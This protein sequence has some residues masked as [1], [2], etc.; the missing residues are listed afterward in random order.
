MQEWVISRGGSMTLVVVWHYFYNT[1]LKTHSLQS[2]WS[3]F[4]ALEAFDITNH[5]PILNTCP[6]SHSCTCLCSL[7]QL[8]PN[9]E[10]LDVSRTRGINFL[11]ITRL[12]QGCRTLKGFMAK[13]CCSVLLRPVFLFLLCDNSHH[14]DVCLCCLWRFCCSL[15]H[16]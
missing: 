7:G 6:S 2:N 1:N 3:S 5:S 13:V 15:L 8:C 9:L 16:G 12:A 4:W 11:Q 14:M 10:V